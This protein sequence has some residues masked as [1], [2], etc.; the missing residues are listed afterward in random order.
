MS[1][2][3][4]N[5]LKT[6]SILF[7]VIGAFC[8]LF[9]IVGMACAGCLSNAATDL[10]GIQGTG[11]ALG[12]VLLAGSVVLFVSGVL[13]LV[14]GIMGYKK[15]GG[16]PH[17]HFFIAWGVVLGVLMLLSLTLNFSVWGLIGL[18]PPILYVVGGY[19]G[20]NAKAGPG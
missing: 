8:A 3:G 15:S 19:M 6:A 18:A 5:L 11:A 7:I 10:T 2:K 4:R 16:P 12:G 14:V 20:R 1:E 17:Y 9:A 13:E